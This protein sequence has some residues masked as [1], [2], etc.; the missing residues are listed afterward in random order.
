MQT[1]RAIDEEFSTPIIG[2]R[3]KLELR[4]EGEGSLLLRWRERTLFSTPI[5]GGRR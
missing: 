5:I 1:L 2:G 3:G 4:M